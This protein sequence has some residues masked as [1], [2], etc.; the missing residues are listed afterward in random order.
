MGNKMKK[1]FISA[2]AVASLAAA[3][4]VPA[5][6]NAYDGTITFNGKLSAQTCTID[7]N[8][9]NA[10]NFAVSLPTVS[11]GT[12]ATA[13]ATAGRTPFNIALSA[14]SPTTG[15]VSVY[16]EPGNT[17][18]S[19]GNLLVNTGGATNVEIQLLNSDATP[20]KA[21]F[22]QASQNSKAVA[23]TSG[24]ATL[25]YFAQYFATGVTTAGAAISQ[26]NYTIAYP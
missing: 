5:A 9:S 18:T 22:D 13:S 8:G 19:N 25:G 12:L 23:L 21:G 16:F 24:A 11:T 15:N 10:K 7:G 26:V 17:D 6:A 3:A 2:A 14:C 1:S 20:I 4:L